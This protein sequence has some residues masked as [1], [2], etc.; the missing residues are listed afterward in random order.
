MA[1]S[2]QNAQP[3]AARM[4]TVILI[5]YFK[6]PLRMLH[7]MGT[8]KKNEAKLRNVYVCFGMLGIHRRLPNLAQ[9]C[10]VGGALSWRRL[11][12]ARP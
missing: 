9:N 10:R 3:Q 5:I 7:Y 1:A 2:R 12:S 4:P 6:F 11:R 8:N